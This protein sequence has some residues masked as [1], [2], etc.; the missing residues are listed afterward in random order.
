MQAFSLAVSPPT[1]FALDRNFTKSF[2][3]TKD[4]GSTPPQSAA[5]RR[6]SVKAKGHPACEL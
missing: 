3:E 4:D 5:I 6:H 1:D 2:S